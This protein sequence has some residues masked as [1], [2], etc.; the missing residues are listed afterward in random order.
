MFKTQSKEI[1]HYRDHLRSYAL[2]R[3]IKVA[4]IGGNQDVPFEQAFSNLAHAYLKDKAPSLLDYEVGF[5]L[6]DRNQEN[7]KAIGVFGFKVGNQWLFAPVFFL[8]G[9]LKGHELLYIKS[10][11][12]FVPMKENWLNYI[13]NRKPN[14]LGEE[15]TRQTSQLGILPPNLYQLSRSPQ[16]FA[17]YSGWAADVIPTFAH[18]VTTSPK[19]DEKYKSVPSL[20]TFLK[21]A[22]K[23]VI[24]SL[25]KGCKEYPKLAET[26]NIFHGLD[27]IKEAIEVSKKADVQS[28]DVLSNV[29]QGSK[30]KVGPNGIECYKPKKSVIKDKPKEDNL[31]IAVYDIDQPRGDEFHSLSD[32]ERETLIREGVLI[33]DKRLNVSKAYDVQSEMKMQNPTETGIYEVLTKPGDWEKC[34]V[35][36]GPHYACGKKNFVTVVKLEGDKKTWINVH[37][38]YVW[39]KSN[40]NS[41]GYREWYNKLKDID[42]LPVKNKGTFLILGPNGQGTL[43]FSVDKEFG[44]ENGVK[45]YD[46]FFYKHADKP[47]PVHLADNLDRD[48]VSYS[49]YS[50]GS[51]IVLTGRKGA[52]MRTGK[53]DLY[54]PEGFKLFTLKEPYEPEVKK[55]KGKGSLTIMMGFGCGGGMSD[56]PALQLGSLDDIQNIIM[57]K[58]ASMKIYHSGSELD[59]NGLHLTPLQGLIHLVRSHG[60]HEKQ[61]RIM[62]KQAERNKIA[63]FRIKYADEYYEL[64]K[65]APTTPPIPEAP[66]GH[67]PMTMGSYPTQSIQEHRLPVTGMSATLTDRNAYR[68]Q[69][70]ESPWQSPDQSAVQSAQQAAQSG[71]KEIFDTAMIGSLLKAT[72]DDSMVDKY[73]PDMMKGMDRIGRI[74]MIFYWHQDEFGERYGKSELPEL[75]DGLRNSFEAVGDILLALRQKT[76][77]PY[78]E[79]MN[80]LDLGPVANM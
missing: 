66:Y 41:E 7:T 60:L 50:D 34:L 9:D 6:V 56:P 8:N 58:T 13:L 72:R 33:K 75:E 25:L 64:S 53:G 67:D 55:T 42:S 19:T 69:G 63:R 71:Q 47:R 31:K 2:S 43:P 49:S 22:G 77:Q 73:L 80:K 18:I 24:I 29:S 30:C 1:L 39:T 78:D 59:I 15:V 74:L 46:V 16:K 70:P 38:S 3:R 17:S 68:P 65:S 4:E 57:N 54:I 23:S 10:Q 20:P 44:D 48:P 21:E 12:L 11:D 37:Q 61:A 14:V 28:N 27:C 45:T 36:F 26:I 35:V 79:D 5:Q 40:M 52:S 51:R 32:K 76:V 62:I